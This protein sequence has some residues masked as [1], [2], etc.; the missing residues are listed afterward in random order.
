MNV[1]RRSLTVGSLMLIAVLS[2]ASGCASTAHRNVT[3]AVVVTASPSLTRENVRFILELRNERK[4]V[5]L[6]G[7]DAFLGTEA[8]SRLAYSVK[9]SIK[10]KRRK[11]E[12]TLAEA[13]S[14]Q[15]NDLILARPDKQRPY[16]DD[17]IVVF[18]NGRDGYHVYSCLAEINQ[19]FSH[20]EIESDLKTIHYTHPHFDD[21]VLE[22]LRAKLEDAS[23]K[24][25]NTVLSSSETANLKTLAAAGILERKLRAL[26]IALDGDQPLLT[27]GLFARC[28]SPKITRA[29]QNQ[30]VFEQ[31]IRSG[32]PDVIRALVYL[33]NHEVVELDYP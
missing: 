1:H 27:T 5:A 20:R 12:Q 11:V 24:I 18:L 25:K 10:S 32:A 21:A 30:P 29:L 31:V 33:V 28:R 19:L 17:N 22:K 3:E 26:G 16:A 4:E 13:A 14:A 2:C 8:G 7:I 9:S 6:D 15:D 23:L